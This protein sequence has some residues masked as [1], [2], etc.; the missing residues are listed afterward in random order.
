[1]DRK[2]IFIT[3]AAS[4]IGRATAQLFARRGWYVGI[5]DV[6][7]QALATLAR[8]IGADNCFVRTMDVTDPDSY[9]AAIEAFARSTRG[10]IDV[11]FNNAGILYMGPC[12]E[13]SLEQQ[14]RLVDINIKGVLVG[15]H[16]AL[17]YLKR[18]PG[19]HILT[20]CSASA[21]YGTP[22]LAVYSAT[23]HAVR[24]IT[25][26]L[27]IELE[28]DGIIVSDIFAPYVNTPMVTG[29][30]RQAHSISVI[31]VNVTAEDVAETAWRAAHG[32]RVH[33]RIHYLTHATA[34]FFWLFPFLKR[35]LMKFLC[36][37]RK[38]QQ[39]ELRAEG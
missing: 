31:G 32:N 37:S 9:G 26:A 1:M 11:L 13:I 36:L 12:T 6:N 28:R 2:T 29:A 5:V 21:F 20:M 19:A 16:V 23:K 30:A 27:N 33:W 17:P 3:G 7:E 22:E 4:G 15:I 38:P 14:F 10:R 39:E 8:E 25:E 24:A 35:P 34:L 18:T